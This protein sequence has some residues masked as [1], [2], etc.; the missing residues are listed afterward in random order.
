MIIKKSKFKKIKNRLWYFSA[1]C[2]LVLGTGCSNEEEVVFSDVIENDRMSVIA[3][4][5][6]SSVK[7]EVSDDQVSA[8]AF[9]ASFPAKNAVDNNTSHSSR[10]AGFGRD[11][12]FEIDLGSA[13]LIDYFNIAFSGAGRSYE[14]EVFTSND[15]S[16]WTQ[17]GT[18]SSGG[19]TS[20]EEFDVTNS[21]ARYIL[22]N[23][24]GSDFNAW[25]NVREIEVYGTPGETNIVN[26][27][28]PSD[29]E[30]DVDFGDLQVETSW[31]SEDTGDRDSFTASQVDNEEWMDIEDSGLVMMTCLAGDSHRTELKERTGVESSLSVYKKMSYTATLSP[32]PSHGVTIAQVHNRQ[33]VDGDK[34]NRPWIRV[35]VDHDGYIKIK[36]TDTTPN[37]SSSTYTVYPENSSNWVMYTPG[38]EMNI[39]VEFGGGNAYFYVESNGES[40]Q[41]TLTPNSDWDDYSE[42]YY[43]KAGVYTEGVD[44]EPVM[45]FRT[46]SI[47]Y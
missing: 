1:S 40:Y 28:I 37:E 42:G 23:F 38:A 6:L 3:Q 2:L 21:T 31:I 29:G 18:K 43:L 7:L 27:V 5:S 33:E 35:Y 8:S 45:K 25:N 44:V 46:F 11:V 30:V 13:S 36:E 24:Q 17:V 9:H 34:V 19:S 15:K 22:I 32:V 4:K 20:L 14:F 16:S 39:V 10:W 26:P 47:E 12:D 41:E